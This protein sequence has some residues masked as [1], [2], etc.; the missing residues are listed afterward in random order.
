MMFSNVIIVLKTATNGSFKT[1]NT[2]LSILSIIHYALDV[3]QIQLQLAN[4]LPLD[5]L[6]ILINS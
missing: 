4:C 2:E 5:Q 1:A 6:P 3:A